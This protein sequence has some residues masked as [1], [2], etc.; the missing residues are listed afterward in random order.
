M[1]GGRTNSHRPNYYSPAAKMPSLFAQKTNFVRGAKCLTK[2]AMSRPRLIALL[3]ALITLLVYLPVTHS[4]FLDYDDDDYVT[5]NQMVRNGLTLAGIQLAF[6]T[7][8]ASNWHPLTW[9]SHMTDCELFG[10][11]PAAHHFVNVLFHAANAVLLFALLL[12]LTA[13]RREGTAWSAQTG[14][15]WP[16]AFVAALFAWH[17][18]HVESVAWV[19]E[20]KDVLSTCFALLSLLSYVRYARED[21]R[22]SLW[23]ALVFFALGLMAKPMLVTLP[24]VMLLLDY[25]PLQRFNGST[26]QRLLIEKIP[27][28]LLVVVSCIMTFLAQRN[29]AVASLELVPI[30][31][32][33][34]NVPVAY[35]AY[36]SKLFWPSNLAVIYPMPSNFQLPPIKV[37]LTV[38]VLIFVSVAIWLN[39]KR[40]PYLPVGW[41]WFLGA[42]VPVIGL[43]QVGAQAFADRYTYFPAIGLFLM[44]AYGARDL[45][46]RY[47][48]SKVVV[49]VLGILILTA[50]VART[51]DQLRYWQDSE[52]LFRHA[53]AVTK[54]NYIAHIN[55]GVA[56]ELEGKYD[57]AIAE[58]RAAEALAP[59]RYQIHNN[60]GNSFDHQGKPVEALAEYREAIRLNPRLPEL[61]NNLGITLNELDRYDE[62]LV[63]FTNAA[64][65]NPAYPWAHFEMAMALLKQGRN[66][67][68]AAELHEALVRDPEDLH[69]LT[70]SAHVLASIPDPQVRDGK[71]ALALATKA[72]ELTEGSQVTVLN[73]LGMAQAE[74]GDF[75]N[76]IVVT[77]M[78]LDLADAAHSEKLSTLQ[79]QLHQELELYRNHQPWRESFLATNAQVKN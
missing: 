55:L 71:T 77:Q 70:V 27:F 30:S 41:L 8:H 65:L 33:L 1:A 36:L 26:V 52:V 68:A 11:N 75:T 73:A 28:F 5:N 10:L 38:F 54:D 9:L 42:L 32:R 37:A 12:R 18:L 50:C 43:V 19:A 62:A 46:C 34:E 14:A 67:E 58:N 15:L 56:L 72:N 40:A 51:N 49:A 66:A 64:Q 59:N 29:M 53:L 57:E 22:T 6:T 47:Q 24:C 79:N 31:F 3:L 7:A 69:I 74:N 60:L 61:H 4:G 20:R 45:A 21:R 35:V 17:P 13:P 2:S 44:V 23:V 16:A 78:A 76:A 39:R 48:I 63:E 25:W